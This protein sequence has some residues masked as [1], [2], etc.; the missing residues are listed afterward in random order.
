MVS[1]GAGAVTVAGSGAVVPGVT[2][3]VPGI[4]SGAT[5]VVV[6]V[7]SA[8]GRVVS[9]TGVVSSFGMV[10]SPSGVSEYVTVRTR[11]SANAGVGTRATAA[12][13]ARR[14]VPSGARSMAPAI[15]IDRPSRTP[16]AS[17]NA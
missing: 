3:T 8:S 4:S 13:S 12:R 14:T 7:C 10:V 6:P 9:V 11:A 16:C 1:A 17:A 15:S 2:G 5:V